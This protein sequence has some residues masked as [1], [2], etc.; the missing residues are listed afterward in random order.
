MVVVGAVFERDGCVLACRRAP[1]KA[2]AGLWEFPGGKVES[3]ETHEAALVREID[4][5]LGVKVTVGCLVHRSTTVTA[6]LAIDLATYEVVPR[7]AFP[8]ASSDHDELRWVRKDN[9]ETLSW[10]A[11]DMPTVVALGR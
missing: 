4:E 6:K 10:A 9:L 8:T 7:T 11:A 5:E 1:G 3:G 2:S